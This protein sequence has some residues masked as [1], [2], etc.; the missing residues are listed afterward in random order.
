MSENVR[1]NQHFT[2]CNAIGGTADTVLIDILGTDVPPFGTPV[3]IRSESLH[4][5]GAAVARL[6]HVVHPGIIHD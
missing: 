3:I 2:R 4:K 1:E 6:R 5:L